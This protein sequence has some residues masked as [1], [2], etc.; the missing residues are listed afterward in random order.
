LNNRLLLSLAIA[1]AAASACGKTTTEPSAGPA[2]ACPASRTLQSLDGRPVAAIYTPVSVTGTTPLKV[3]CTPPG[4]SA[5]PVGINPVTCSVT[6][7][8]ARQ[9]SCSFSVTVLGQPKISVTKFTAFG[10][11]ITAGVIATCTTASFVPLNLRTPAQQAEEMRALIAGLDEKVAYPTVLRSM[12]TSRYTTQALT[13]SNDGVGGEQTTDPRTLT[14]L[15][16]ALDAE[17]PN[18]LLLQE[19][20]NDLNGSGTAGIVPITNALQAMVQ[21]ARTRGVAVLLGTL[22]PERPGTCRGGVPQV[23]PSMNDS[24]RA[25]A[26]LNGATLVDLYAAF[27]G[28]PDPYIGPDGL[29]PT[30]DGYQQMAQTFFAAIQ[31]KFE[32]K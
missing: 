30:A 31:S 2:I 15:N 16:A 24:I 9:A 5:F 28:S 32:I 6:D 10:D 7:A 18:V 25:M 19:G 8:D 29:H 12:L 4:G 23:V 13:V 20:I 1:A 11:S 26:A 22:L 3:S 17:R 27:N 21:S 14:R